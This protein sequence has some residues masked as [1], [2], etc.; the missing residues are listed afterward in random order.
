M[1]EEKREQPKAVK[2]SPRGGRATRGEEKGRERINQEDEEKKTVD[3]GRGGDA[4]MQSLRG[5][6]ETAVTHLPPSPSHSSISTTAEQ[7]A[8]PSKP[9]PPAPS[10]PDSSSASQHHSD[11]QSALGVVQSSQVKSHLAG[12]T[13]PTRQPSNAET[14]NR[15]ESDLS[16]EEDFHEEASKGDRETSYTSHDIGKVKS[17]PSTPPAE[18]SEKTHQKSDELGGRKEF[19]KRESLPSLSS[20]TSSEGDRGR[21][22]QAAPSDDEGRNTER[23]RKLPRRYQLEEQERGGGRRDSKDYRR[24][25]S[26]SPPPKDRYR[27]RQHHSPPHDYHDRHSR[28]K[29]SPPPVHRRHSRSPPPPRPPPSPPRRQYSNSPPYGRPRTPIQRPARYRH[30]SPPQDTWRDRYRRGSLSPP[31]Y[32][33]H[34]SPS[35]PPSYHHHRSRS[36]PPIRRYHVQRERSPSPRAR[37]ERPRYNSPPLHGSQKR[38]TASRTPSPPKGRQGRDQPDSKRRKV[39]EKEKDKEREAE[40]SRPKTPPSVMPPS[41]EP[42]EQKAVPRE[43]TPPEPAPPKSTTLLVSASAP[44]PS[45]TSTQSKL[46]TQVHSAPP[47]RDATPPAPPTPPTPP[48]QQQQSSALISLLRRYP[49]M[50]QGHLVLKNDSAAVQLHFLSGRYCISLSL[51]AFLSVLSC[52]HREHEPCPCEPSTKW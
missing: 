39:N 3:D 13:E 14:K 5:K 17:E 47:P 32:H 20:E 42:M 46:E 19:R 41:S 34:K 23:S 43:P 21:K 36:P 16:S 30:D 4:K 6:Q 24:R 28:W 26:L 7:Q 51:P 37:M 44:P 15:V 38:T 1:S 11:R 49:V 40:P 2:V 35:P 12:E 33:R 22:P 45:E 18:K 8:K 31:R 29:H 48:L 10:S 50:W 9:S 52:T 25:P 27:R